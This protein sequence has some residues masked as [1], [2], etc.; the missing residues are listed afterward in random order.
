L[1]SLDVDP[2]FRTEP[3]DV[4]RAVFFGLGSDG[5]VG[6]NRNSI[7][8]IGEETDLHAQGYF[9][10]DSKK[11]GSTTVS[12][13]RFGPRPI[14][15]TYLVQEADFVACHQFGFL[16]RIDV[17]GVAGHGAT[18]LLN[19]PYGPDDVWEHLPAPPYET[20]LS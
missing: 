7:R 15:S 12:H 11:A 20:R 19:A 18:F 10:L 13:L 8:I 17:L 3:D 4:V 14:E 5:T 1:L 6:A 16:E 2:E 9:V